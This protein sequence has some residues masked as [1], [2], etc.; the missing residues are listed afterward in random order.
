MSKLYK[1]LIKLPDTTKEIITLKVNG[2]KKV[3]VVPVKDRYLLTLNDGN[4]VALTK[5]QLKTYGINPDT[6][7]A[8]SVSFGKLEAKVEDIPEEVE[9]VEEPETGT[10]EPTQ[11][12]K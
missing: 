2:K 11:T 8:K 10:T 3:E 5:D 7:A 9:E 4:S 6:E 12:D 1:S